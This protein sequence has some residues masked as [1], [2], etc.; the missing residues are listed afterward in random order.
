[1]R[2]CTTLFLIGLSSCAFAKSEDVVELEEVEVT[3]SSIKSSAS[4]HLLPLKSYSREDIERTGVRTT[5]DLLKYL[6]EVD[7]ADVE[8]QTGLADTSG[9]SFI[10]LRGLSARN[11][12]VLLNGQRLPVSPVQEDTG[13]G[14]AVNINIIPL[15]MIER[16]E[17]LKNGSSAIYGSDAVA[18]VVNFITKRDFQGVNM[19]GNYGI[20]A[21][22]DGSEKQIGTM[23]GKGDLD[24]DG[25]NGT[26]LFEYFN[27]DPI[28]KVDRNNTKTVD[29][30]RFGGLDLRSSSAPEGNI[31]DKNGSFTGRIE[32]PCPASNLG[33]SG[34]CR[35]NYNMKPS[36]ALLGTERWN[37]FAT[38]SFKF[39]ETLKFHSQFLYSNTQTGIGIQPIPD[40]FSLADG[41]QIRG[42][43]MQGGPR[44]RDSTDELYHLSGTLEGVVWGQYWDITAGYGRSDVQRQYN[45]YFIRDDLNKNIQAGLIN[46]TI[47]TNNQAL[48]DSLKIGFADPARSTLVFTNAKLSGDIWEHKDMILDYATGFQWRQE[49]YADTPDPI[50]L[51]P[52]IAGYGTLSNV[53]GQ[54]NVYS[55][56]GELQFKVAETLQIQ[57]AVRYD[58]YDSAQN[59]TPQ[60][61]ISYAP[62]PRV[63]LRGNWGQNFLMPTFRQVYGNGAGSAVLFQ[64]N[65]CVLVGLSPGCTQQPGEVRSVENQELK[66]ERSESWNI[67]LDLH[68]VEA[69]TASFDYWRIDKSNE[70][71]QPNYL[72]YLRNGGSYRYDQALQ[73]FIID[74]PN[75]NL[76][77]TYL[78]GIDTGTKFR[79]PL[80][81]WGQLTLADNLTYYLRYDVKQ[82][83]NTD[84]ETRL[85]YAS[86]LPEWR[87]VFALT[88]DIGHWSTSVYVR[89]T[90][91]F[92]DSFEYPTT[93]KPAPANLRTVDAYTEADLLIGYKGFKNLVLNGGVKNFTNAMPPFSSAASQQYFGFASSPL[94]DNRGA[95]FFLT[96]NYHF[97]FLK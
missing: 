49:G 45:N 6:P 21:Y 19:M 15:S 34:A 38:G 69:L 9:A 80:G 32:Q 92:K 68:P 58:H 48:V 36:T 83:W 71:R 17:I 23:V 44:T 31:I 16:V 72:D 91:G 4:S 56:F 18:G 61:A 24:K 5:N 85:G 86:D 88:W 14:A 90:A 33:T 59:I 79:W 41:E 64:D 30:R 13:N 46:P 77:S 97:D 3:G 37:L 12:L 22:G 10:K 63:A 26:V 7:F 47:T 70:V 78:E 96:A 1:M 27:R 60:V 94:Y 82:K 52:V 65:T 53:T 81:R 39:T 66:P 74:L 75:V 2:I 29:F 35:F 40:V 50:A 28:Y 25:Y 8:T 54:R 89:S 51:T 87:N 11:T 43:F 84:L 42:R 95:Y 55:G 76:V 67:G 57:T 20:T 73:K 62:D 93:S